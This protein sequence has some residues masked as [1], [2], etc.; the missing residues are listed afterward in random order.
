M[1]GRPTKKQ[2]KPTKKK[3]KQTDLLK[4]QLL[5][6]LTSRGKK[7][8]QQNQFRFPGLKP[9][10]GREQFN[11][12]DF[13]NNDGGVKFPEANLPEL[14][15]TPAAFKSAEETTEQKSFRLAVCLLLQILLHL[16]ICLL[17]CLLQFRPRLHRQRRLFLLPVVGQGAIRA[18]RERQI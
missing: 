2:K 12:N 1:K 4:A 7:A 11:F 6:Q 10:S 16:Q 9:D 15:P 13:N 5:G 3:S 18:L 17:L 14:A 8:Q